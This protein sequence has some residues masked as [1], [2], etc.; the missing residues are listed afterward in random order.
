MSTDAPNSAESVLPSD[1]QQQLIEAE[2]AAARAKALAQLR[3]TGNWG[4]LNVIKQNA[5]MVQLAALGQLGGTMSTELLAQAMKVMEPA[6]FG[7]TVNINNTQIYGAADPSQQ[8]A[9]TANPGGGEETPP[10]TVA[11]PMR[12]QQ[13]EE[14]PAVE[15]AAAA[16]AK[17][18]STLLQNVGLMA[19]GAALAA[20]I[21]LGTGLFGPTPPEPQDPVKTFI[22]QIEVEI[23]FDVT[24]TTT[25][26]GRDSS[27]GITGSP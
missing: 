25:S 27:S 19:G 9:A 8:P 26:R 23:P 17:P 11:A 20:A 6:P 12:Q 14:A 22:G 3:Y 15:L 13:A 7:S 5:G 4:T 18:K 1:V 2:K 24:T 21:A 16:T 10:A